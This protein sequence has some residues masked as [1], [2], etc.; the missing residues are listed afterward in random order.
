VARELEQAGYEVI[1][2][3]NGEHDE[4]GSIRANLL[5]R[6][7]VHQAVASVRPDVVLH[8]A[9]IAFV[10]HGDVDE[11]YRVNVVGTRNLLD[12]LASA[13]HKPGLVVLASSANVYGNAGVEP[14]T[15]AV[16]A[17]PVN[18]YAV[19]KLAMEYAARLW[20]DRLPIVTVRPFNY[21][22]VGQSRQFLIPKIVDHFQRKAE[23]IELGNT[24]VARDFS[25]VR[26]VARAYLAVIRAAPV[27]EVLNICSG[28][29]Y[30]LDDVLGMMAEIAGYRIQV[31]VNPAFVRSSDVARL[32]GSP[33]RL[34]TLT[35]WKAQYPLMQTLAWQYA[36][37]GT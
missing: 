25:D 30:S 10:A 24:A 20:M 32:V 23:V 2:L 37:A 22:G 1:G 12:A 16:P 6:E 17:A 19:S 27:G 7:A 15:E 29:G 9:A 28:I 26:D 5:D 33:A 36:E 13:E 18:D 35:G 8:L 14:I 34:A 3:S 31:K 21:T 11:M 4:P